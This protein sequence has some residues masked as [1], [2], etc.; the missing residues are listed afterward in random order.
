MV[1][2]L[3]NERIAKKI[4]SSGICS[5]REAERL[6]NNGNVKLNGN[7][8]KKCN[9]NV[10]TKDIIEVN[11]QI[12]KEK[13]KVR[14]WLYYKKKGFLVTTKDIKERPNIFNE[15]KFKVNK[16]LISIGRLDFNSEGLLLLTNNGD[17]A[18]KLELPQNKFQRTYK[19]RIFGNINNKVKDLLKNGIKVNGIKYK[20]IELEL[21][22]EKGQ[23]K[24]LTMKL[25]EGKNREIRKIMD[26]FGCTVNRLIR[27][28]YGPFNLKDLK[29][30]QLT[31]LKLKN[32][33]KLLKI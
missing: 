28:S 16:R 32:F 15:I 21:G 9:I 20:P 22:K 11:N 4:A 6:I 24:W 23:N 13:E 33:T 12:L 27:I 29:P 31:E 2:N 14:L 26:H 19:V 17:F 25:Y 30:G 1:N 3:I 18:R 5:R 8:I 7:V 10:T